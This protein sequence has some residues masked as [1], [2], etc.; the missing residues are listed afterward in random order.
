MKN[1]RI[2][3]PNKLLWWGYKHISGTYQAKRYWDKRDTQEAE[4]SEFCEQVV[5]PFEA[6]TRD[7]AIEIVKQRTDGYECKTAV[8]T[9]WPDAS[10]KHIKH[11]LIQSK[12][13]KLN[14]K[15]K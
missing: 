7:E 5:Y 10:Y 9:D 4:E 15:A 13:V 8:S 12:D 11:N 3:E 14:D 2:D 6:E 1:K